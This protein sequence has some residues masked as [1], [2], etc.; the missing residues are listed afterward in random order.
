METE[1]YPVRREFQVEV[2]VLLYEC[3]LA[4]KYGIMYYYCVNFFKNKKK[5][6]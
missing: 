3:K 2:I 1:I 4:T 5:S 6:V